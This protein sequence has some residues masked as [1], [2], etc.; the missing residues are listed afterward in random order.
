MKNKT[1]QNPLY[2]VLTKTWYHHAL[3]PASRHRDGEGE[4]PVAG[5][6]AL[7]LTAQLGQGRTLTRGR[8]HASL[9]LQSSEGRVCQKPPMAF[10]CCYPTNQQ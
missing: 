2:S 4:E 1:S 9:I 7:G 6:A 5:D 10:C 8:R 3:S